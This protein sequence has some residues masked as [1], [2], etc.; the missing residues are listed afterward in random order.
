M[1]PAH[2]A[3]QCTWQLS[4][5]SEISV[6]TGL[7]IRDLHQLLIQVVFLWQDSFDRLCLPAAA[8]LCLQ[9]P[10]VTSDP[11][12]RSP[13]TQGSVSNTAPTAR[14]SESEHRSRACQP[15]QN[16]TEKHSLN[17]LQVWVLYCSISVYL[18]SYQCI[19]WHPIPVHPVLY[20]SRV[21]FTGS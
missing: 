5:V 2:F 3:Q 13:V 11:V 8:L 10:S 20:H 7:Y 12:P 6:L 9:S 16:G 14:Q 21:S 1:R 17:W 18:V 4:I 15:G 19:L